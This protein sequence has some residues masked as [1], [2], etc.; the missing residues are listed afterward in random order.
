VEANVVVKLADGE[1]IGI[2]D[3][4]LKLVYDELWL[5]ASDVLGAVSTAGMIEYARRG[6]QVG[7]LREIA[8]SDKQ[9][10]VFREALAR[11]RERS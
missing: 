1:R 2:G 11:I 6:A 10:G 8:L 9:S 5:R 3:V 7:V 4:E